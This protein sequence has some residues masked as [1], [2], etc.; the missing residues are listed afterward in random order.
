M[1]LLSYLKN[2]AFRKKE[3]KEEITYKEIKIQKKRR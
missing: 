1:L 3:K 2:E